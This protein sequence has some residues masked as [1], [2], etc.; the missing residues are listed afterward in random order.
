MSD[1]LLGRSRERSFEAALAR[2]VAAARTGRPGEPNLADGLRS[3]AVVLA[4][5]ESARTGRAV[6]VVDALP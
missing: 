1:R 3:L 4:A 6:T 2:F 5:E